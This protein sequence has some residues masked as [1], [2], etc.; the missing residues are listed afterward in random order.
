MEIRGT[1]MTGVLVD[2]GNILLV[3]INIQPDGSPCTP[4]A[5]QSEDDTRTICKNK[6]QALQT[7]KQTVFPPVPERGSE[8]WQ[9]LSCPFGDLVLSIRGLDP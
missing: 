7:D 5:T 9:T 6:P 1:S 2:L 4:G 8:A 3:A